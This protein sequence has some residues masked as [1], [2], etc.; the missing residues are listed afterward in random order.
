MS[1]KR[2]LPLWLPITLFWFSTVGLAADSVTHIASLGPGGVVL[3]TL[4]HRILRIN[5]TSDA[6]A[7]VGL[8]LR[9]NERGDVLTTTTP[10]ANETAETTSAELILPHLVDTGG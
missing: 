7:S 8:G 1:W 2:A 3:T 5:T 6:A 4:F 10:P 9:I